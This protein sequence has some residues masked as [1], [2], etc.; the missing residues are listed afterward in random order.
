MSGFVTHDDDGIAPPLSGPRRTRKRVGG[1]QFIDGARTVVHFLQIQGGAHPYR[2]ILKI[3]VEQGRRPLA[4]DAQSLLS[5]SLNLREAAEFF[6]ITVPPDCMTEIEASLQRELANME[7]FADGLHAVS[8]LQDAGISVGICS[9]LAQ[10]YASAV[11]RLY[12]S[13]HL[14]AFS[15]EA[16]AIKPDNEIY[17]YASRILKAEH[18]QQISMVGDSPRCDR[19]GALAYGMHGYWLCRNGLG[20]YSS[21]LDFAVAILKSLLQGK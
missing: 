16:G 21:L 17:A 1:A 5:R 6:R 14:H 12:P 8:L 19:D 11:E 18:P 20:D 3:G 9:N 13:V 15:F 2:A 4:T 7:P 10:P